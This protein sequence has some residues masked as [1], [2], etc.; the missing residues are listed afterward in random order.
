[1]PARA[2]IPDTPPSLR[3]GVLPADLHLDG[4]LNEPAWTNAPA[5]DNL[6]MTEPKEGATPTGRT[7]VQVL[8]SPR[9]IV[10]GIVCEDP[11]P[12]GIV[13]YTRQRDGSMSSE[14][15]IEIVLDTFRDG[16]SGYTFWVNPSG[17]RYD[18]LINPG[19]GDVNSNWDGIWEA[20]TRKTETGWTA[21]I[22]I[23]IQ[24]LGFKPGLTAWN[25][26]IQRRVQ[27]LQETDRWASPVRDYKITQ[28][29]R[30]GLLTNLPN[31]DLGMGLTVRP[32]VVA[33]GGKPTPDSALSGDG[34]ASLDVTKRVGA[35]LLASASVN[36]DFAET[37]ADTRQTNLTRFSLYF[38]EKRA[39]FLE[40]A[41][42]FQFGA[43]LGSDVVPFFSRSIGLVDHQQVPIRIA[44]KLNGRVGQT[45]AG[46]VVAR[47]G[48][49][50]GVAPG[51]TM[52]AVRI[53]QD[54]F[55]ESSVGAIATFGDPTGRSG[56][57]L[58]G[59]DFTYQTS[60]FRGDKNFLVGL[61][62]LA[63]G[64]AGAK[65]DRTAAGVKLAYPN[66]LWNVSLTYMR[67]GDAF[68]PSLGFVPR[69]GVHSFSL[70]GEYDPRPSF[71]HIRQMFNEFEVVAVTDL[72][73]EWESYRV[74][75]APV[76]WRFESGDRVEINIR[77]TGEQLSTPFE[78]ADGV[79]IPAGPY[80]F[81]RYRLEAGSAAKRKLSGQ[82]TWWFGSFY[83]GQLDQILLTA[84]WNP[85]ALFTFSLSGEHDIGRLREGRFDQTLVGARTQIN[86]SPNL[87]VSSFVQYDTDSR[88]IGTN[89][90]LR[91]TFHPLGDLFVI[92][93]HNLNDITDRWRLD[94]NQ[95][96]VKL[97]CSWRY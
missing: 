70:V 82:A 31:F 38:P 66:D 87:Q 61:W 22:R 90:R 11:D 85:T 3:V 50:D 78:I 13:S 49:V 46:A 15:H 92:Y 72:R 19:G 9:A 45:S 62:G 81:M 68:Q 26:N 43:G 2:Q 35:N 10:F 20:A 69:P 44:G 23:P 42:I 30:A 56:S 32:S 60:H 89:T 39:F 21:E 18:A 57:W 65:D 64:Q 40:G 96:L 8:A 97:Q 93:N 55:R 76:N 53:K 63:T 16:R 91:W 75:L 6:T 94:S 4:V 7:R 86:V 37:E 95:L 80:H 67:V 28:M 88:T 59:G 84:S 54:I 73:G 27:R 79:V 29:S 58:A 83:D 5:I 34:H 52:G 41:D 24:T 1:M 33:G 74:F 47:T 36:T 12:R 14:D 77:P 48:A 25:F 51:S 17:A 71:W